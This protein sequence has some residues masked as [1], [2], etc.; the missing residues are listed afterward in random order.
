MNSVKKLTSY[1]LIGIVIAA[2]VGWYFWNKR[3]DDVESNGGGGGGHHHDGGDH[4]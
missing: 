1:I 4:K 2:G 3:K